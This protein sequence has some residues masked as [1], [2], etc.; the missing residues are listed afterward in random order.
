MGKRRSRRIIATE[1]WELRLPA[2][3]HFGPTPIYEAEATFQR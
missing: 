2:L 1:G 3:N